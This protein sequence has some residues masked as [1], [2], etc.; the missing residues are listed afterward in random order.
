MSA[1]RWLAVV[2]G[3]LVI[4]GVVAV[5]RLP[6][7]VRRV[8]IARLQALTQR[9]VGIDRV[10]LDLLRGRA[11]LQGFRLAERDG[12]TPFAEVA[13]LDVGVRP[14]ALLRGHLHIREVAVSGSTVH[15]VRLPD[16]TFNFSDLVESEG[17]GGR[18][19]DLTVDRLALTGGTVTL[20]DRGLP[21]P[22]TW[23]SERIV[24]TPGGG[25]LRLTGRVG[26]DPRAADVR[27]VARD[28]ALSPYR[29]YLP[30]PSSPARPISMSPSSFPR[31]RTGARPRVAGPASRA[32]TCATASGP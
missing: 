23:I 2:L 24:R 6:E 30:T 15:V 21:E 22:R 9:P 29:P 32:W 19:L 11:S 4:G 7:L 13:R 3:L 14:L 27:V 18:A 16:G 17:S 28:G 8:A 20:E 25:D 5:Y 26:L 10:E 12:R 31:S 1:R